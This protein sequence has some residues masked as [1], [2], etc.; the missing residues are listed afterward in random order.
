LNSAILEE[1][2]RYENCKIHNIA[3]FVGGVVAEE[4]VKILAKQFV[5]INNTL[6]FNGITG[7]VAIYTF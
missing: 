5:P 7:E 3:A 1:L 4:A 2:L 6:I